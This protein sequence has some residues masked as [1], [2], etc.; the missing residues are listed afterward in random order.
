MIIVIFPA[1]II[2]WFHGQGIHF[3]SFKRLC[4]AISFPTALV[5]YFASELFIHICDELH[6]QCCSLTLLSNE[7]HCRI[8]SLSWALP[9]PQAFC[10]LQKGYEQ[11]TSWCSKLMSV[12]Y[13]RTASVCATGVPRPGVPALRGGPSSSWDHTQVPPQH[14]SGCQL[15]KELT[16]QHVTGCSVSPAPPEE[17]SLKDGE[18]IGNV[19]LA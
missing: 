7:Q 15:A 1:L 12:S 8:L 6:A 14:P 16:S 3:C 13:A 4:D 17:I 2:L 5:K 9:P 18:E 11:C 10:H 19:M